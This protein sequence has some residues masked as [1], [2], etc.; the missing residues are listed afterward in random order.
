MSQQLAI[1]VINYASTLVTS[2]RDA[3]VEYVYG[4]FSALQGLSQTHWGGGE[5]EVGLSSK[6]SE[7]G[8]R[9]NDDLLR[10]KQKAAVSSVTGRKL[11]FFSVSVKC[12][13]I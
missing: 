9:D 6:K 7:T 12:T 13:I 5:Q 1:N 8:D 3:D 2:E 4:A 11:V 10:A